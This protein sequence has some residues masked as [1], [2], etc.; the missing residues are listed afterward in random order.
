MYKDAHWWIIPNSQ[1][2]ETTRIFISF[3]MDK[4][5]VVCSMKDCIAK[6]MKEFRPHLPTQIN[7]AKIM[8]ST[9][10]SASK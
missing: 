7:R 6:K 8:L 3:S 5:I 4:Y 1:T 9:R 2:L 10:N